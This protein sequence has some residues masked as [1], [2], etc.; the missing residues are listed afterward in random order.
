M[1][2]AKTCPASTASLISGWHSPARQSIAAE[3]DFQGDLS[4]IS[5][6]P[7]GDIK[8]RHFGL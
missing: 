2:G 4:L 5:V 8:F 6:S 3:G 7:F 1:W